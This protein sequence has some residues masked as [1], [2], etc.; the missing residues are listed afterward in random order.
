MLEKY[1]NDSFDKKYFNFKQMT[2]NSVEITEKKNIEEKLLI[3]NIFED[4]LI[5][6]NKEL[7]RTLRFIN[8]NWVVINNFC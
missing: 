3:V 1:I 5:Y 8:D 4:I 2:F 7:I 6:E